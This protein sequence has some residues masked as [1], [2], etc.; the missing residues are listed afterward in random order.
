RGGYARGSA[1]I[2]SPGLYAPLTA[3][4]VSPLL[5]AFE[6]ATAEPMPGAMVDA[7]PL[8]VTPGPELDGRLQELDAACRRTPGPP[9]L[10][11]GP[12]DRQAPG[13]ADPG[14]P[15]DAGR[16]HARGRDQ[17]VRPGL[18]RLAPDPDVVGDG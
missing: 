9:G 8:A 10:P 6:A 12:A 18:A 4:E 15:A 1:P 14:A 11:G 3:G 13:H 7:F 2:R 16:D 5:S 17:R